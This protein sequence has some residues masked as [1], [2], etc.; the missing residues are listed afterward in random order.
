MLKLALPMSSGIYQ[1]VNPSASNRSKVFTA[2][3]G[4]GSGGDI[5]IPVSGRELN[6]PNLGMI[7]SV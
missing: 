4:G 5:P 7:L 3:G 1:A 6:D 2:R